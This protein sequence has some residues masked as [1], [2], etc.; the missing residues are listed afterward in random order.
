MKIK[1]HKSLKTTKLNLGRTK[2][3]K[4][5]KNPVPKRVIPYALVNNAYASLILPRL[6][7]FKYDHD[8]I[9]K[10]KPN[11]YINI[12]SDEIID[13]Y[14]NLLNSIDL[15]T[16]Y[17]AALYKI[18]IE[19]TIPVDDYEGNIVICDLE[20]DMKNLINIKRDI[21]YVE[22]IHK[23][24]VNPT[25]AQF[26]K[27]NTDLKSKQTTLNKTIMLLESSL[28]KLLAMKEYNRLI[29]NNT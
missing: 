27:Y 15:N 20:N 25:K 22:K 8:K 11:I 3:K 6:K 19:N 24:L 13:D 1:K 2:M 12:K 28:F 4:V 29:D 7:R 21:D 16:S 14:Y 18:D 23:A 9:I 10:P 17:Q 5:K 26:E